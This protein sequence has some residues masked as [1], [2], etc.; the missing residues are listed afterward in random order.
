MKNSMFTYSMPFECG[1]VKAMIYGGPFNNAKHDRRLVL[2]KMA[3]EIEKPCDIDIPTVD[4]SVP[5]RHDMDTGVLEAVKLI[6]QGNDIY[7]GCMGGIGRTGLFMGCMAKVMKDF[8]T[9][10][11]EVIPYVRRE[12]KQHAIETQEQQDFVMAFDTSK[13]VGFLKSRQPEAA[14][15]RDKKLNDRI[16]RTEA[17]IKKAEDRLRSMKCYE[18]H[19]RSLGVLSRIKAVFTGY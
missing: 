5:T 14:I 11:G 4:F 12:F 19:I 3:K 17:N 1:E 15:V 9:P 2:V 13:A 18:D 7:V 6:A 16:D 10:M 8:G